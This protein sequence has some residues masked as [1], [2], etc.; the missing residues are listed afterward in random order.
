M[1][2]REGETAIIVARRK[3]YDGITVLAFDD[4]C[5]TYANGR[6]IAHGMRRDAMRLFM[7]DVSS[8]D[9]A[10]TKMLARSAKKAVTKYPNDAT[11]ARRYMRTLAG[12]PLKANPLSTRDWVFIGTGVVSAFAIL[13]EIARKSS[14]N[15]VILN[16]GASGGGGGV[17]A[18]TPSPID[19]IVTTNG[20]VVTLP[21][22]SSVTVN[23]ALVAPVVGYR[24]SDTTGN[25]VLA[26]DPGGVVTTSKSVQQRWTASGTTGTETVTYQGMDKLGNDLAGQTFSFTANVTLAT[27]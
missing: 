13:Y 4:E 25:S 12:P 8:Y 14:A 9:S 5:I 1:T 20:Q 15:S 24:V 26:A 17:L 10:E 19:Q 3:T 21:Q 2:L 16:A 27:S 6:V 11:L 23:L 22:G 7:G 18:P